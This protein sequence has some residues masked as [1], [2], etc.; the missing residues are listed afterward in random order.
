MS[1]TLIALVLALVAVTPAALAAWGVAGEVEPDTAHDRSGYMWS[2]ASA[3]QDPTRSAVYFNGVGLQSLTGSSGGVQLNALPLGT[4]LAPV[5][6]FQAYA[7]LGL[8]RDC[9]R[10]GYVGMAS[11]ALWRYRAEL[12]TDASLCPAGG[13]HNDGAWV[14]EFRW[15]NDRYESIAGVLDPGSMVWGDFGRPTDAPFIDCRQVPLPRGTL[16]STGGALG[17]ADCQLGRP[18]GSTVNA[19]DDDGSK[20]LRF[21][22]PNHPERDCGSQLNRETPLGAEEECE[23][24]GDAL[25][26]RGDADPAFTV[27]DCSQPGTDVR[28]PLAPPGEEGPLKDPKDLQWRNDGSIAHVQPVAPAVDADGSV[29]VA[30]QQAFVR[31]D[32]EAYTQGTAG[33]HLLH[34]YNVASLESPYAQFAATDGKRQTDFAFSFMPGSHQESAQTRPGGTLSTPLRSQCGNPP[35]TRP[36]PELCADLLAPYRGPIGAVDGA[37]GL[38]LKGDQEGA[39]WRA[40]QSYRAPTYSGTLFRGNL[41]QAGVQWLTFYAKLGSTLQTASLPAPGL[42]TYGAET[43]GIATSGVVAGWDCDPTHWWNTEMGG[44]APPS[45][46]VVARVGTEYHL[47]DVDCLDG[48]VAAGVRV[49][50]DFEASC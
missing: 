20:G 12:L 38:R 13:A 32:C 28:N 18:V 45:L 30:L 8:W 17:W 42:G 47:R 34:P 7:Y 1:R 19:V 37:Y 3:A 46:A 29:F 49:N 15:I 50:A 16:G 40:A 9:D 23:G 11:S 27:W 25:Y 22:D 48:H 41:E 2:D 6:T 24:W 14:T 43:C 44:A 31:W 10:D 35:A 36:P 26:E 39:G 4:R 33:A 21:E 5:G